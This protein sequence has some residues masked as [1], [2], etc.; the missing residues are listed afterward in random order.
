[1]ALGCPVSSS[2]MF[3]SSLET[4]GTFFVSN[5]FYTLATLWLDE[6]LIDQKQCWYQKEERLLACCEFLN[7]SKEEALKTILKQPVTAGLFLNFMYNL[8]LFV[9]QWK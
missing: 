6:V 2:V 4:A 8:S 9:F 5:I 1:M 7:P 3:L